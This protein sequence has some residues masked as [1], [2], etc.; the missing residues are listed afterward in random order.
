MPNAPATFSPSLVR[1]RSIAAPIWPQRYIEVQMELDLAELKRRSL[2]VLRKH[3]IA[4]AGF[5]G[6]RVRG[7]FRPDS[8]LDVVVEPP[9][10]FSLMDMAGLRLD[11][12]DALGIEAHLTTYGT[13]HPKMRDRILADEVRVVE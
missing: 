13:L 10:R 9:P 12:S 1:G 4:R 7:D 11:L 6:S 3:G 8:D 2:P 5:Y